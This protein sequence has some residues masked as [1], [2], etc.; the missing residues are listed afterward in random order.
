MSALP[1]GENN[2]LDLA[3]PETEPGNPFGI[4]LSEYL[5]VGKPTPAAPEPSS[6]PTAES[7]AT[8]T[9]ADAD[10][11]KY[12]P[13]LEYDIPVE[14]EAPAEVRAM[15]TAEQRTLAISRLPDMAA[16]MN[17]FARADD[18]RNVFNLARQLNPGEAAETAAIAA[19]IN[20][21]EELVRLM[22][23][24][25]PDRLQAERMAAYVMKTVGPDS[26]LG[27]RVR[28]DLEYNAV[29]QNETKAL[30]DLQAVISG[31]YRSRAGIL[32]DTFASGVAGTVKSVV[33]GIP[34]AVTQFAA[35]MATGAMPL[36][37][38][39][40]RPEIPE[41]IEQTN[42][43]GFRQLQAQ[44][45]LW[46]VTYGQAGQQLEAQ[47][48]KDFAG[49]IET[50]KSVNDWT[51]K[52]YGTVDAALYKPVARTGETGMDRVATPVAS[53]L[54]SLLPSLAAGNFFGAWPA[55]FALGGGEGAE[56]YRDMRADNVDPLTAAGLALANTGVNALL[57]H[58]P[59]EEILN[60][61]GLA[62]ISRAWKGIA[63]NSNTIL[64][65]LGRVMAAIGRPGLAE[66]FEEGGQTISSLVT[67]AVGRTI[68]LGDPL[69]NA[70]TA[71]VDNAD[72]IL[73]SMVG[74]AGAGVLAGGG[75][76]RG[77]R[78]L[79]SALSYAKTQK[80]LAS[81]AKAAEPL[82]QKKGEKAAQA[83]VRNMVFDENARGGTGLSPVLYA[84]VGDV[85]TFLQ[86]MPE[87]EAEQALK[88]IGVS[89]AAYE[90]AVENGIDIEAPVEKLTARAD[91]A[92]AEELRA[93]FRAEP[94][95][96]TAV[97]LRQRQA[98]IEGMLAE[99]EKL[100]ATLEEDINRG[101]MPPA[102][103]IFY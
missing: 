44:Q 39:P 9:E 46:D 86:G 43:L 36:P 81:I 77:N 33:A 42:P 75:I 101:V 48:R 74:G 52:A 54:G 24:H 13:A 62:G 22:R 66:A 47:V 64:S 103:K 63:G 28:G 56:S 58:L 35:D 55:A 89:R 29:W 96:A 67:P 3:F 8:D 11:E 71:L 14:N 50:V 17:A 5:D 31:A 76:G 37:E 38:A 41:G 88:S 49:T 102:V 61:P 60:G 25:D 1:E 2:A 69:V 68:S 79:W 78:E 23:K 85:Q 100:S 7:Q 84:P 40:P 26:Y 72:Q 95:E 10:S 83:E 12:F 45:A 73:D 99:A 51:Q 34:A 93:L 19:E 21:P 32:A 6:G 91:G 65:R 57:E 59:M 20:V 98:A 80:S 15:G 27:R 30:A 87:A 16:Q 90:Q 97:H 18:F 82:V 4:D 92:R 53:G 70:W 94:G